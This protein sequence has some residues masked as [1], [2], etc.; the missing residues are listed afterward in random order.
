VTDVYVYYF[1]RCREPAGENIL[2]KRRATLQAIRGMGEAVMES[3]IVVDHTEVDENGFL[4]GG[5]GNESHPMDELWAQIRSLERRANSR[6]SEALTLNENGEDQRAYML[7]LESRELRNQAQKLK[8]QRA[9][10]M[11][12]ELGNQRDARDILTFGGSPATG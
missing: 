11:A 8:K 2:S 9:D 7:H 3:Q 10:S 4:I 5:I 6:D 12:G 1:M